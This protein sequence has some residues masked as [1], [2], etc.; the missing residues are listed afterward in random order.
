MWSC[1][2]LTTRPVYTPAAMPPSL[3]GFYPSETLSLLKEEN[4]SFP[5]FASLVGTTQAFW[6]PWNICKNGQWRMDGSPLLVP[7][8]VIS[9]WGVRSAQSPQGQ[10]TWA[11]PGQSNPISSFTGKK[12][13][14]RGGRAGDNMTS[15]GGS[16]PRCWEAR[17]VS[18]G[19]GRAKEFKC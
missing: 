18:L 19:L 13:G 10:D 7:R 16:E 12:H 5:N 8:R 15:I 14:W 17:W 4:L 11:G 1:C 2:F 6:L 9:L 3:G